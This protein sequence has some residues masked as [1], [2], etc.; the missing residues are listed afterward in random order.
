MPAS[1]TNQQAFQELC[2]V[3]KQGIC[4]LDFKQVAETARQIGCNTL[5]DLVT[6]DIEANRITNGNYYP[7]VA[8]LYGA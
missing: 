7:I 5:A 4:I 8:T 2:L 6:Q 3:S 1:N